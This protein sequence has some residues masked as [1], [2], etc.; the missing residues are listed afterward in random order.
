MKRLRS[1][2]TAL[3][4]PL[5][6]ILLFS[7]GG[8]EEK[9]TD[10]EFKG[11]TEEK[12][13]EKKGEGGKR[14][15]HQVPTPDQIFGILADHDGEANKDLLLDTEGYDE[16]VSK[17]EQ[18]LHLG[19]HSTDMAYA[20]VFD[21][22]QEAL[23]HFKV[24]QELGDELDLTS[25]FDEE[26]IERFEEKVGDADSLQNIS[27]DT[28][29]DAFK[30]LEKNDR[31]ETLALLVAGGW[32]EALYLSVEMIEEHDEEDPIVQYVADQYHSYKQVMLFLGQYTEN[33]T[34]GKV[35]KKMERLGEAFEGME[36]KESESE[37]KQG[38]GKMVLSGG[39]ELRMSKEDLERIR[40]IVK[41][42]RKDFIGNSKES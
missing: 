11:D 39:T 34:V 21:M 42:L 13:Q 10:E 2:G 28:Y 9:K 38:D 6:S 41:D 23:E 17:E 3:L 4:V 5:L 20:S 33:E 7:C 31:G 40:E 29:L 32:T 14:I 8:D 18:A 16:L 36:K 1:S 24:V 15:F 35:R 25:A 12:E 37:M 30:Y 27:R 26:A 19:L 22:G